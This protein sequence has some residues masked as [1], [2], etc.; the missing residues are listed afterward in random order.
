M[1]RRP[2]K[3][4][5]REETIC[6][7]HERAVHYVPGLSPGVIVAITAVEHGLL[8][9][10]DVARAMRRWEASARDGYVSR[11]ESNPCGVPGC[12]G[13]GSRD[14]LEQAIRYLPRRAKPG[15]RRMV[16]AVDEV[17]LR[18]TMP[19]PLADPGH[20]GGSGAGPLDGRQPQARDRAG[21]WPEPA[22]GRG[23]QRAGSPLAS[24]STNAIRHGACPRL[25]HAWL[26]PFWITTSP[27]LSSTSSSSSSMVIE[28]CS[29]SA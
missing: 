1:G 18:Q 20:R 23:G 13:P 8:R 11:P 22:R 3:A 16:S 5:R 12:S 6:R 24:M 7:S 25:A 14:L 19:D 4:V 2:P 10:G 27:A 26:V 29:T 15:L 17:Y 9:P 28:P 21:W